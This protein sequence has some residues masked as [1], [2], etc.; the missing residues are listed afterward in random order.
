M[1]SEVF[2]DWGT[3]PELNAVLS[4]ICKQGSSRCCGAGS[5][6]VGNQLGIAQEL[7]SVAQ[8]GTRPAIVHLLKSD[9]NSRLCDGLIEGAGR[10]RQLRSVW[11]RES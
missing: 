8:Q 6:S 3:V 7:Q 9:L 4:I 1:T 2:H 11:L 10:C 5:A